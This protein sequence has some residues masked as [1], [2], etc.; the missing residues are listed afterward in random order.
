MKGTIVRTI[1]TKGTSYPHYSFFIEDE[2]GHKYFAEIG[3]IE[4]NEKLSR[5]KKPTQYLQLGDEVEFEI[6]N[7]KAIHIKK[8]DHPK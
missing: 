3:D 1:K 5:K 6:F 2:E 8:L 4:E 7:D